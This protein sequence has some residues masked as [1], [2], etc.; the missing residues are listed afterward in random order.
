VATRPAAAAGWQEIHQTSDDVR[1]AVGSDGLAVVTHH[2]RYRVVA[3]RFKTLEF[4]GIDTRAELVADA[5]VLPEKGGEIAA[6]V[7]PNAKAP[8]AVKIN[9]D[10]ARGLPRGSYAID[11]K[12]KLDLVATKMLVRDGAMWRLSWTAPASPEG[13]DGARVI[14][15][16]PSAPTEPR[17]AAPELATTTLVTLRRESD[18]DELELVRA[19]IPR[20]EAVTWAARVDPKAFPRVAAPEL[21]PPPPPASSPSREPSHVPAVLAASV[22][23]ALSGALAFA[24]RKKQ[25]TVLAACGAAS[26]QPRP[27]VPVNASLAPFVYAAATTAGLA[28][29]LWGPPVWGAVL[30][31]VAMT[32]ATYRQPT[33]KPSPRGPGRWQPV[34]DGDVLV[35]RAQAAG[36][37]DVL[38]ITTRRGQLAFAALASAMFVLAFVLRARVPGAAVALPLASAALVPLF[39]TGTRAQLPHAPAEL[40][41]RI[42]APARDAL[43]RLVDLAHVDVQCLARF[44]E[45]T[46]AF[47][48]VRLTCAPSDRIPGLRVIELAVAAAPGSRVALPEVLV[49]F[50]DGSAAASKVAQIAPGVR[51]VPGRSPEEKVLRLVPRIPTARG[52]ARLLARLAAELEGRRV[53]DRTSAP[54]PPPP[55]FRGTE[56][57]MRRMPLTPIAVPV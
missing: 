56:R 29:L 48:E 36:A 42:L 57:R 15:E 52:A 9:V 37:G 39:A 53:S 45:G 13:H 11:V 43:G 4:A 54:S 19:H 25:A 8:G 12:Y 17:L 22:L 3:G 34:E 20:G 33:P 26:M 23:A 28:L 35:R 40:A 47:D 38:D 10:D 31:V 14:F 51:L 6:R 30:V 49:R 2:L 1:V 21:R 7:E 44:R 24:L 41:A 5:V 27:L 32:I 46:K 18:H 50:D 55:P 16:T